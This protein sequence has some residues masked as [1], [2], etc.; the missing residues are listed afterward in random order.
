M[1]KVG[2]FEPRV[3]LFELP[4]LF[5]NTEHLDAVIEGPIGM[6]LLNMSK[7]AGLK[8]LAYSVDGNCNVTNSKRPIHKAEDFKGLQ[9]RV[10][11]SPI[12]VAIMKA[13]GANPVPIAYGELYTALQTGVVDGQMN[14]NWVI[15][16]ISLHEV[17]KYLSVTQHMWSGTMVLINPS[18]FKALSAEEQKLFQDAALKA[19]RFGRF[20]YRK[21]EEKHLALAIKNGMIVDQNPDTESMVKATQS[22]Y[23]DIYKKHPDWKSI[24]EDIMGVRP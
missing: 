2:A 11:E 24:I 20:V 13:L 10:M 22:V 7:K 21:S 1:G 6:K 5:R 16:S 14:P 3:A 19:S 9:I 12:Q 18:V 4:F 15:T 23:Q 17:Q 8:G